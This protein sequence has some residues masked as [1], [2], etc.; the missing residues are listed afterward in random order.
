MTSP[1]QWIIDNAVDLQINKRAVTAST[2]SRDWTVRSTSRGGRVWRLTVTPSP[3]TRW[4][5]SRGF[6]EA[7]DKADQFTS[8]YINLS[9][10]SFNFVVGYLGNAASLTGMTLTVTNGSDQATVT[11]GSISSGFRF[12]SG[13]LIQPSGGKFVYSVVND[14]PFNSTAVTLNRPVLDDSGSYDC[15]IGPNVKWY[16]VCQS[17]PDYRIV[18]YDRI[19]WTGNFVFVESKA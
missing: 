13:D 15:L 14:V 8:D 11:G 17:M 2:V 19:E 9:D 7:L 3:G 16:V 18:N 6:I 12:K 4:S 1:F 5:E 10:P